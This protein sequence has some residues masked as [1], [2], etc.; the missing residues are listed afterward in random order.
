VISPVIK[1]GLV[2]K[3]EYGDDPPV[4]NSGAK[5]DLIFSGHGFFLW[6]YIQLLFR[7]LF[8]LSFSPKDIIFENKF[9]WLE[10]AHHWTSPVIFPVIQLDP[11][12]IGGSRV[13]H[14]TKLIHEP[15]FFLG[16][17]FWRQTGSYLWRA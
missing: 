7:F 16:C 5:P 14:P 3:F 15:K 8:R 4:N 1:L 13:M 2:I 10:G 11:V 9:V 17:Q 6:A 12:L